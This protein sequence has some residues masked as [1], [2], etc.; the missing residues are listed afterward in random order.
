[1][2]TIHHQHLLLSLLLQ[3][4]L[5]G[6]DALSV[7]VGALAATTEN[8]E[9][10]LITSG[11]GDGRKALLG[12]THEVV[13]ARCRETGVDGN[14]EG[15]ISAILEANGEGDT[16]GELTVELRFGSTGANSGEGET[17]GKELRQEKLLC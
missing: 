2:A 4:L 11:T 17:V 15:A 14:G 1:M 7:V 9:A 6:S 16:R 10:V 8:H 12:H 13:G 3:R 5:S